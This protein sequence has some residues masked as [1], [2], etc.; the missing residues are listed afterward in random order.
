MPWLMKIVW[1]YD[2]IMT[3]LSRLDNNTYIKPLNFVLR[4][5]FGLYDIL[6]ASVKLMG[7]L[8]DN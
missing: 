8:F 6:W 7:T 5:S 3:K 4:V 1:Y 2:D